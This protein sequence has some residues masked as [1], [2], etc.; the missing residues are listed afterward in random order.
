MVLAPLSAGLQSLTSIPTIKLGPSSAASRVGGWSCAHS[1]LLW[2]SP[3]NSSVRLG[4]SPAA[5]S[6][7]MGVFN[8]RLEALFPHAGALGCSVCFTPSTVPSGLSVC[9]CGASGS[10]S[11]R[12]ACPVRSTIHH[13][14][15]SSCP[16]PPW[17]P[18]SAPPT[19]LD[20][21]F[22]FISLVFGLPC[23]SI[24]CQFWLFFVFKL[25]SFF[26]LC[27]E[28]QCVYLRLHLDR[29]SSL[30]YLLSSLSMF[31]F[32]IQFRSYRYLMFSFFHP[33]FGHLT[34]F[35]YLSTCFFI[36]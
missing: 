22:F 11:G 10:A 6:T 12:T 30:S 16:S 19:G 8:Q 9:E 26:W 24:F 21:C 29:T 14:S 27:E 35:V 32:H 31:Q 36:S 25:L 7:P 2:V 18:L 20:E 33:P 1:R 17:L 34:E 5:A 3:M 28:V 15:G 23:S 13:F 4:V